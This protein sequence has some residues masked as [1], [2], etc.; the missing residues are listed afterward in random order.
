LA[1][2]RSP[3]TLDVQR[4]WAAVRAADGNLAVAA[5]ALKM[6]T[7]D[8]LDVL[9]ES[10]PSGEHAILRE[11][12]A[13][14]GMRRRFELDPA[15]PPAIDVRRSTVPPAAERPAWTDDDET[16]EDDPTD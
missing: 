11:G 4:V 5:N 13:T 9:L 3:K 10:A 14:S 16:S 6:S 12:H 1:E 2:P 7:R 8:V 15:R